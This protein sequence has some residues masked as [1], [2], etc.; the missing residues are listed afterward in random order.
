MSCVY[1]CV[2]LTKEHILSNVYDFACGGSAYVSE[3]IFV[4]LGEGSALFFVN[5]PL[6]LR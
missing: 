1:V 4:P 5:R 2:F 6:V 3:V